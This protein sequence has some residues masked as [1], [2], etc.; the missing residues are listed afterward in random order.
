MGSSTSAK[1][2]P[3]GVPLDAAF[4]ARTLLGI[5]GHL[6]RLGDCILPRATL[7]TCGQRLPSGNPPRPAYSGGVSTSTPTYPLHERGGPVSRWTNLA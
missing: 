7:P 4:Q 6:M 2:N 5:N 3:P 1:L